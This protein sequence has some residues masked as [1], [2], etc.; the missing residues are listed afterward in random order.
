[1]STTE[2][3]KRVLVIGGGPCGLVALRNLVQRGKF[4]HVELWERRSEV[5]GVWHL[6]EADISKTKDLNGR[7]PSPAYKGLV[8][9]VLPEFL[10]FSGFPFPTPSTSPHQPFPTLVD[11]QAYL[12]DFA[13]PYKKSGHIKLDREAI[14]VEEMTSDNQ[15]GAWKVVVKDWKNGGQTA[16][17]YWDAV[18]IA[19]G[20]YDNPVWPQIEGMD[21]LKE[22]GLATHAKWYKG[23]EECEGK[24][25]FVIGNANS[26][27]DIAAQ[28]SP[29]ANGPVFQSIR[30]PNFPGFP[31]LTSERIQIVAPVSKFVLK[32]S[33]SQFDVILSDG[34]TLEDLDVVYCG[35]GYKPMTTF[36]SV[37]DPSKP[38]EP[39]LIPLGSD[40]VTPARIP[41]LHR[42][43]MYAHNPTLGFVGAI[44]VYTPFIMADVASTW[45]TLAWCNECPYPPTPSGRLQ[46][47]NDRLALVKERRASMESPT[48]FLTYS[49]MGP[50]EQGY[51]TGL[52]ED[53]VE[54]RPE[55]DKVLPVWNN[56]TIQVRDGMFKTK[57]EA[58]VYA[59]DR[60]S[61]SKPIAKS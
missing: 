33:K 29:K 34:T 60:L 26:S 27:N 37:L 50:D 15:N 9:N 22:A 39:T 35:T 18:V 14:S 21:A 8:G 49:V 47:E 57:Y 19:V 3:P 7:F 55:L 6:D 17:Q 59:R 48:S 2:V 31:S 25:I 24:K 5:G 58:L 30:R 56:E 13:E 43:I 10:G 45:L 38:L 51:A 42:I 23:P 28:T 46:F 20:Q 52:R 53:I 1:M 44:Y 12:L 32:P 11:T 41:S 16:V 54:A 4:D 61:L 36:I 40:S